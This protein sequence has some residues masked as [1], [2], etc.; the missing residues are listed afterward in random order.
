MSY[1]PF[2]LRSLRFWEVPGSQTLKQKQITGQAATKFADF[3]Y[4]FRAEMQLGED[5]VEATFHYCGHGSSRIAFAANERARRFVMKMSHQSY[6]DDDNKVE[7]A[8]P[9]DEKFAPR[10]YGIKVMIVFA[11]DV[12]VLLMEREDITLRDKFVEMT[13]RPA[14]LAAV[15]DFVSSCELSWNLFVLASGDPYHYVLCD[16]HVHLVPLHKFDQVMHSFSVQQSPDVHCL[17]F[18]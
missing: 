1:A 5:I 4:N 2:S 18:I 6:V 15:K 16:C 13:K 9:L 12:S 14:T 10:V 17:R 7:A 11:N 3:P 8:L